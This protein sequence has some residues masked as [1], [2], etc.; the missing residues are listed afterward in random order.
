MKVGLVGYKNPEIESLLQAYAVKRFLND[1]NV[2][3]QFTEKYSIKDNKTNACID[4][5]NSEIGVANK[6]EI[7]T[8]LMI[9]YRGFFDMYGYEAAFRDFY[10]GSFGLKQVITEALVLLQCSEY[11]TIADQVDETAPYL[12]LHCMTDRTPLVSV[13]QRYAKAHGLNVIAMFDEKKSNRVESR[14]VNNPREYLGLVKNAS[15][16]VT[17][18]FMSLYFAVIYH[19]N[20]IAQDN[21][22]LPGKIKRFLTRINLMQNYAGKEE[23]DL[24]KDFAIPDVNAL[25]KEMHQLRS[26]AANYL[27]ACLP[28]VVKDCEVDAPPKI[29]HSECCGCFACKEICPEGAIRMVEDNEGFYY[30]Q[31]SDACTHCNLCVDACIKL[32]NPRTVAYESEEYPKAYCAMNTND[33]IRRESTSGGVFP[34][35]AS[36]VIEQKKGAVVGAVYT[37]SMSVVPMIATNMEQVKR[38]YGMK[39]VKAELNGT[40][41][42]VKKYLEEGQ[43][44]VYTGLPCECAALK[45]YLQKDYENLFIIDKLCH[46][47]PSPKVFK[48]YIDYLGEKYNSKITNVRFREKSRGWLIHKTSIAFEFADRSPLVVNARR[49]NYF[50]NYL[51]DNISM[52]GCAN[53]SYLVRNRVG[54]ITLGD[55][56][57]IDKMDKE[58]FDN[59]GASLILVNTQKGAM[60]LDTIKQQLR[61][62]PMRMSQAFKYNY[63]RPMEMTNERAKIF[64]RIDI[65]SID[66]LLETYND[67]KNR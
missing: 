9:N 11:D 4:F 38:I 32:K 66:N 30:P 3:C 1:Y 13:A 26:E 18:S 55:F 8:F 40:Y 10:Q 35:I 7:T 45:A 59:N 29:M 47:A 23:L 51:K 28:P 58:M 5:L 61:I 52:P 65:E 37:A 31:V 42:K 39:Y 54:D 48:K 43:Y 22:T 50:R 25:E 2:E 36:Y 15:C 46:S 19:K 41:P 27:F 16:I 20:F 53:C 24:T 14:Q 57:G 17:D 21:A 62:K 12:I 64:E 34:L 56:W 67:L 6:S 49:N 33:E 44:V 60:M 63:K